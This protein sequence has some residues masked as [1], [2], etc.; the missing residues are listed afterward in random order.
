MDE[1]TVAAPFWL[2]PFA[3]V[4]HGP[5]T[6]CMITST[7]LTRAAMHA[8]SFSKPQTEAVLIKFTGRALP[9]DEGI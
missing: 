4:P 1:D 9:L 8:H 7:W 2:F 6:G 3:G 5:G